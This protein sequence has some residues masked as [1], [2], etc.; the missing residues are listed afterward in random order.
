[1]P[2]AGM[3]D[4]RELRGRL[5][6]GARAHAEKFSWAATAAGTLAVYADAIARTR[7]D[8]VLQAVN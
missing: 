6:A 8:R 4:D 1:M 5:A 7:Q 3:L 2:W